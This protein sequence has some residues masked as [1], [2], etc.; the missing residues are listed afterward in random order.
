MPI[1]WDLETI[2]V[3]LLSVI[4][5]KGISVIEGVDWLRRGTTTTRSLIMG[6]MVDETEVIQKL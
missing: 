3:L 5:V 4:K 1:L 6:R 2:H